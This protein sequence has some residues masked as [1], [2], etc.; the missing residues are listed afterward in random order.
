MNADPI[1]QLDHVQ[2][3]F[4]SRAVLDDFSLAIHPGETVVILGGSGTGKSVALKL[5]LGLL[6]A[7]AGL[8]TFRGADIHRMD[9]A[10]L[11]AMRREIGMLFQGGALFDSMTVYE[12]V[13][14]PLREHYQHPEAKVQEIVAH[15]LELIGLPGI[16]TMAPA[17]LSGGMR[18]RVALARAIATNPAV[19]LYDEPTTGL[20]PANTR[21]ISLLIR[22]LQQQLHVTSIVVTHDMASAF[23]VADRVALLY[24]RRLEFVGTVDAARAS[25]NPVVQNFIRGDLG[26]EDK[27]MA[28][29][30]MRHA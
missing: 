20:D 2:K 17:E 27:V 5:I 28:T 19:I 26:E 16:E 23:T 13:A 18:K 7:D 29:R 9:E 22:K 14:Y 11:R 8:V 10:Q 30:E 6:A 25:A 3:R 12:N 1:I 24:N 21:R 15:C 4:G